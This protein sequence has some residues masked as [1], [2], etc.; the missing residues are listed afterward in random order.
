MLSHHN[1]TAIGCCMWSSINNFWTHIISTVALA[2]ALYSA[3]VLERET[4]AYFLTLHEIRLEPRNTTNPPVDR[5]SSTQPAESASEKVLTNMDLDLLIL[6]PSFN[7]PCM[8]RRILLTALQCIVVGAWRNWHTLFTAKEMSGRVRVWYC[9][10]P[11]MLLYRVESSGLSLSPSAALSFS[12]L[13]S[14]VA[15]DLHWLVPTLLMASSA[16]FSWETHPVISL[17][18]SREK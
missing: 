5:R 6:S 11:T 13:D 7:V 1:R 4:V 8:Y 10:A 17:P 16:Y 14:G 12:T 9:M 2:R 18:Q 15:I 3:S